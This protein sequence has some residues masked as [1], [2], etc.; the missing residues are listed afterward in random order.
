MEFGLQCLYLLSVRTQLL[1]HYTFICYLQY[2]LAVSGH[3]QV[4]FTAIY[5][6]KNAEVEASL[7]QFS[8]WNT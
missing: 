7:L 4:H 6:E 5:M 2:V 1:E 8:Y 3:Q